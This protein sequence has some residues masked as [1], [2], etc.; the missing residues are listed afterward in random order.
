M[1]LMKFPA[2]RFLAG[3]QRLLLVEVQV[4]HRLDSRIGGDLNFDKASDK[5]G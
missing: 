4:S 1:R 5:G 3:G 2:L